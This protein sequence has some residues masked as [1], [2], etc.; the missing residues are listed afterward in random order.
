MNIADLQVLR[1][2]A[3]RTNAPGRFEFLPQ[4]VVVWNFVSQ[5]QPEDSASHFLFAADTQDAI[6]LLALSAGPFPA[7]VAQDVNPIHEVFE[8]E[9]L[10]PFVLDFA[11]VFLG[12]CLRPEGSK[13]RS[14]ESSRGNQIPIF[15]GFATTMLKGENTGKLRLAP[16]TV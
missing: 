10:R 9:I 11:V 8:S 3:K 1:V 13:R 2:A 12:V 6:A 16:H 4:D 5:H 15:G 14:E 7:A